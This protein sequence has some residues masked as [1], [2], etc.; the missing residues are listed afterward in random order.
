MLGATCFFISGSELGFTAPGNPEHCPLSN[1]LKPGKDTSETIQTW[2]GFDRDCIMYTKNALYR[3]STIGQSFEDSRF[4]EVESPVG[5]AG[6]WAAAALDGQQGHIFLAKSGLY[7]FDG[8]RVNEVSDPIEPLFTDSSVAGYIRPEHMGQAVMVTS[9]DR[10]LLAYRT[11]S[12]AGDNDR[13]L[14]GDFQDPANP[15]FTVIPWEIT[16]MWREKADNYVMA[17]D[18][19]GYLWVLDQG[20][21][22]DGAV[23][24]WA[25]TT[26]E[27]RFSQQT[28]TLFDEVILDADFAGATTAVVVTTRGR[29]S[30]KT[31]TY[32]STASGRQRL[33]FK[34][35][36]YV[37]GETA[38]VAVSSSHAGKRSL[39]EVGFTSAA[40]KDEP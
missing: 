38:Q 39:Y 29:G 25:V 11:T 24:A 31:A 6:E 4:E 10:M 28:M 9:R 18:S 5:L 27:F 26:K 3:L 30:I 12:G 37:K 40:F 7:L 32:S 21:T 33:A 14:W 36:V 2:L 23:I 22:N 16:S 20:Y 8:T 1:R 19:G 15:A 17:G 13:L 35:P 34:L